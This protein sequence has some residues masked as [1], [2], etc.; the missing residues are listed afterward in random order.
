MNRRSTLSLE[1]IAL[2]VVA[3]IEATDDHPPPLTPFTTSPQLPSKRDI[4]IARSDSQFAQ[5]VSLFPIHSLR[6]SP[7]DRIEVERDLSTI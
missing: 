6:F 4:D 5:V 2:A 3:E 1:D 7:S